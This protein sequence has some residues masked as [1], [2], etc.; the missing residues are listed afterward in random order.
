M[1]KTIE[2][3]LVKLVK[4]HGGQALK[5][6]CMSF[7]GMPDRV[8]IFPAAKIFFV[9]VKEKGKKPTD[10]QKTVHSFLRAYGFEV[11]VIDSKTQVEEF[12][13]HAIHTP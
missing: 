6:V 7:T 5:M 13:N 8:V 11:F 4:H 12:I 3:Y 9:E 10:R 1:E 2:N